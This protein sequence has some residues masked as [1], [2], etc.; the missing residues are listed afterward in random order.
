MSGSARISTGAPAGADNVPFRPRSTTTISISSSAVCAQ[1][2]SSACWARS[3]QSPATITTLRR[4][5]VPTRRSYRA[6]SL[7]SASMLTAATAPWPDDLGEPQADLL[8]LTGQ[9]WFV[10]LYGSRA[11]HRMVPTAGALWLAALRGLLE[12]HVSAER[13]AQASRGVQSMRGVRGDAPE[14]RALARRRVVE[15]AV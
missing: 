11:L 14:T 8:P 6:A 10:R 15:E 2:R 3:R 12:W 1:R 9:T 7:D 5:S 13:R 4:G